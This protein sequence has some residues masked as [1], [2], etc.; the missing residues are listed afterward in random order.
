MVTD[1]RNKN[2]KIKKITHTENKAFTFDEWLDM[3]PP[4]ESLE[5]LKRKAITRIEYST[6]L[7]LG[8]EAK[9]RYDKDYEEFKKQ[10]VKCDEK[11]EF[12]EEFIIETYDKYMTVAGGETKND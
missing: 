3:S 2:R 11:R 4:P 8:P 7:K 12:W 6:E 10:H 9:T 5:F 1:P